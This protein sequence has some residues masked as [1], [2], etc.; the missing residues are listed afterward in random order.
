M[1]FEWISLFGALNYYLFCFQL[2]IEVFTWYVNSHTHIHVL[3]QLSFGWINHRMKR[4]TFHLH[5]ATLST[6]FH[7]ETP[8]YLHC[9]EHSNRWRKER[10]KLKCEGRK[11][12]RHFRCRYY[13]ILLSYSMCLYC[14]IINIAVAISSYKNM[15]WW[16]F[17]SL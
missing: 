2:D 13:Y 12:M 10:L 8:G 11:E 3:V 17:V 15:I 5:S 14:I 6:S 16:S 4:F 7:M 1:I 9:F